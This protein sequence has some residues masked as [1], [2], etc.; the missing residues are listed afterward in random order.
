MKILSLRGGGI[1]GYL[2]ALLFRDIESAMGCA[3]KKRVDLLAGT[4]TGA[5]LALALARG[6]PAD[7]IVKLYENR[8]D[9]IFRRTWMGLLLPKYSIRSLAEN[10]QEVFGVAT[11]KDCEVRTMITATSVQTDLPKVFK[12][13]K[14][15]NIPIWCAAAASAAAPTYFAPQEVEGVLYC[16]GGVW[17]QSPA[18][19]AYSECPKI[20]TCEK[21]TILDFTCG[22]GPKKRIKSWGAI[23]YAPSLASLFINSSTGA[24][25]YWLDQLLPNSYRVYEP[26][27]YGACADMDEISQENMRELRAAAREFSDKNLPEILDWMGNAPSS[28]SWK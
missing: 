1:R 11:L 25:E 4:S 26:A 27:L 15:K 2:L 3:V 6:I 18:M 9:R 24:V 23:G 12:S 10:L 7:Q 16:D 28:F 8:A 22:N 13:W 19:A 14:H 20:S 17:A 5:L 21:P